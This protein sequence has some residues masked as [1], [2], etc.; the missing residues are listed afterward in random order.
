MIQI[1]D[2]HLGRAA[3]GGMLL[4]LVVLVA[5]DRIFDVIDE[6]GDVGKGDFEVIHALGVV[7]L[8]LPRSVYDLFPVASVV[9]ALLGVGGLAAGSELVAWRAAGLSRLRIAFGVVMATVGVLVPVLLLGEVVAPASERMAASLKL[10]TQT[11]NLALGQ[12]TSI[13][14][15][16]GTRFINAHRPLAQPSLQPG[17]V[18]LADIDILEFDDG[19]LRRVSHAEIARHEQGR[20]ILENVS[21]STLGTQS[22]AVEKIA[23]ET[24]PS[25]VDPEVLETAI[26]RPRHLS[27]SQ[28]RPYVAYL[29]AN[30]LDAGAYRAAMWWRL[31]YPL[32]CVVIVL[33]GMIFVFGS[34]RGGGLGQR[35]FIG[36]MLGAGFFLANR[37]AV[38]IGEV[39]RLDPALMAFAPSLVVAGVSIWALRRG[40]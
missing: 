2:R 7:A 21:R 37:I 6:L 40:I 38:S 17:E 30:G 3:A 32:T 26:T 36:M 10:L 31:A 22:V 28:L 29:E 14:V 19:E 33:A 11:Q 24:W 8:V 9:G 39:Y 4:A 34:L 23:E 1:A 35:M 15:R 25:L 20:W 12:G 13:W 16:D 18:M 5:L 27:L